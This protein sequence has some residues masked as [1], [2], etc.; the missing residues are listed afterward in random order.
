MQALSSRGSSWLA[1]PQIE[2]EKIIANK[3]STD[4]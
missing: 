1:V 4:T 3:L 2:I